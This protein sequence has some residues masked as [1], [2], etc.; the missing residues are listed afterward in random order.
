MERDRT[1]EPCHKRNAAWTEVSVPSKSRMRYAGGLFF[2]AMNWSTKTS[3]TAHAAFRDFLFSKRHRVGALAKASPPAA[4]F[5]N[6]SALSVAA[7]LKSSHPAHSPITRC[8]SIVSAGCFTLPL[9]CPS[10]S[11]QAIER[12]NPNFLSA[13]RTSSRPASLVSA[14]PSKSASISR[15]FELVNVSV[16]EEVFRF[17]WVLYFFPARSRA[18]RSRRFL[19]SRNLQASPAPLLYSSS[20]MSF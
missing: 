13:S 11:R 12:T 15:L 18:L 8:F 5:C 14:P 7:S 4:F 2:E 20:T 16:L 9:C 19:I 6:G 17:A 3:V 10:P 1:H